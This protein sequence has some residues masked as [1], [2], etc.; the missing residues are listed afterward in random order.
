VTPTQEIALALIF[1]DGRVLVARRNRG[2]LAGYWEF[3]GGKVEPG[4]SLHGAVV[5]ECRE[6]LGVEVTP[7]DRYDPLEFVYPEVRVVLHPLLCRIAADA[8]PRPLAAERLAWATAEELREWR[9][10][11]PN[12]SLVERL[13]R[14][15]PPM[16]A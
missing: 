1:R 15:P 9:L 8:E 11:E 7:G 3:P 2:R 16:D 13:I 6:E 14:D 10:P 5:R 12:Y 4:E